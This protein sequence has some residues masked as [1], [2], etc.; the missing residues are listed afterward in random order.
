MMQKD[1]QVLIEQK[2][3]KRDEYNHRHKEDHFIQMMLYQGVLRYNFGQ[4]TEHMQTFLLYS[5][6]AD[7]LLLEHFS[8]NLFR[9]SIK[10]RNYIVHNE[11]RLGEGAIG[12]VVDSL[13]TDL[14]NELQVSGKLWND[15]QEPQLQTA[16]NT[17]KRCTPLERAYFNRFFTF[18]AKEQILSKTGGNSDA[19]HGF[20]GNW[21]IPLHE[22]LE[23]GNILLRLTILQKQSSGPG[24]GY[25]LIEL[26]IPTQEEDFLP[27]FRTGDMVILYSYQGEPDLR[28]QILMKGNI[29]ALRP[30]RMT[31]VLRNGQQNKDIIG[32]RDDLFAIEHDF[33]IPRPTTGSADYTPFCLPG[34][35]GKNFVRSTYPRTERGG[36]HSEW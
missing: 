11:M 25:D 29:L 10:L 24:K 31:L 21:H 27:N 23:A 5:K 17:L 16:I 7:G 20:A 8:E 4:E 22:K 2:A 15:Y 33:P 30:D 26:H 12:E 13:S 3:G 18:V 36:S 6:Y 34:P 19:S 1:F 9:E 32:G 28:K 14:L 35:T